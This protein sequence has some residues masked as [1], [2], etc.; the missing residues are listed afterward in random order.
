[1]ALSADGNTALIGGEGDN[2]GIG[3]AWVFTQAV[4]PPDF[5]LA[6]SPTSRTMTQAGTT[7]FTVSIVPSGG[8][9]STVSLSITGLPSG[10]ASLFGINPV[11]TGVGSLL[12]ITTSASTPV[13]SYPLTIS[14]T[15][16]GQT[17]S[18]SITLV[19]QAPPP[20]GGGGE[21]GGGGG[22]GGSGVADLRLEGSVEPTVAAVGDNLTW[23]IT[24]NDYNT[25][26]ATN[27]WV[28]IQLPAS[29]SLV[30]SYADRGTG[31][32]VVGDN[33]LHCYLDWLADNVQFGHVILVTKVTAIGDH[34]LT[35]VTGYS[36]ADPT[37]ADNTMTLTATTP[38]PTPRYTPPV[39]VVKPVI[40]PATITPAAA[41]GR[42]VTVS[43]KVTRSD[44]HKPLA[45]GTMIC[46]PS[47]QAKVVPHAEQFTNG[48]ARLA[49][50]IPKNAKGKL[51][52]V[53]LTIKLAG[54]SATTIATFHVK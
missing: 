40:G 25:G 9:T 33:K 1:M 21:S 39:V 20:P 44:N 34:V 16:G 12:T 23:R 50:T 46:D 27:L 19:V 14:G 26:P 47:I 11:S 10:A 6:A 31:C 52:K 35:A 17:R 13:G 37:P 28:D 15:S 45:K 7:G 41:A 4:P 49:F 51:L 54:Q 48:V 29:V 24:V 42:H 3:A 5:A 38:A 36:A 18:A 2:G 43:F 32:A 8:F 30:S 22:S 53:H